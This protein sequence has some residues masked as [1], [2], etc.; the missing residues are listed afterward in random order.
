MSDGALLAYKTIIVRSALSG[1]VCSVGHLGG[2][3]MMGGPPGGDGGRTPPPGRRD[4]GM[5]G[6][7]SSL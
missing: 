7:P 6:P 5:M 3:G 1:T 4:G 2:G